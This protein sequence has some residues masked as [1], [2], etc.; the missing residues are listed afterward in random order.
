MTVERVLYDENGNE[1]LSLWRWTN[2]QALFVKAEGLP[3]LVPIGSVEEVPGT[4]QKIFVGE[5]R[6]KAGQM[7]LT[8][9]THGKNHDEAFALQREL[10]NLAPLI[11][12][13]SRVPGGTLEIAGYSSVKRSFQ[14]SAMFGGTVELTLEC[15]SPY[16][17]LDA[18]PQQVL[19]GQNTVQVGGIAPTGI[20][21]EL[22]ASQ[23]VTDPQI[24][25]DA[26]VTTWH[27]TLAAGQVF[28]MDS[29]R[30]WIATLD[31]RDV[32]LFITG[33]LPSLEVGTRVLTIPAGLTGKV[34]WREGEL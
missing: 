6:P 10:M 3:D 8:I 13:Y 31:G 32:S 29:R 12:A 33:P 5:R 2:E 20:R 26:G 4:G 11:R 9:G 34:L 14:G 1:L 25:T 19:A 28:V 17:W 7:T 16:F 22:T 15:A 18:P 23:G 24:V 30:D 21:L 27:G